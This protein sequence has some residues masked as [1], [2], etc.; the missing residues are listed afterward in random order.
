MLGGVLVAID[1]RDHIEQFTI[2]QELPEQT[3]H[4]L[5]EHAY[6]REYKKGEM[7]YHAGQLRDRIFFSIN[8]YVRQERISLEGNIHTTFYMK[9]YSMFP[10]AGLFEDKLYSFSCLAMTNVTTFYI[11]RNKFE[12]MISQNAMALINI[13]KVLNQTIIHVER[14][15]RY[16]NHPLASER[17]RRLL[18][19]L[20]RL[21]GEKKDEYIII[22]CPITTQDLAYM[23]GT[24]RETVSHNLH[25]Y[26]NRGLI[27]M[28]SKVITIKVPSFFD[29]D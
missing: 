5:L 29:V 23:S 20:I 27:C 15:V 3:V 18:A 17:V 28:N 16:V 21:I 2:F 10:Y 14:R 12:E 8:G 9:P 25:E 22:P 26:M 7:L 11:P 1:I 13:I 24:T 6:I 19:Y 4:E